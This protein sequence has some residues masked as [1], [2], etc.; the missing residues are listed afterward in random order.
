ME[1]C[2]LL[3]CAY[4]WTVAM[5]GAAGRKRDMELCILLDCSHE[6]GCRE[7]EGYGA[8]HTAGL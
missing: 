3:S 8:V 6:W 5:N 7:K 4:C 2:I 1:L